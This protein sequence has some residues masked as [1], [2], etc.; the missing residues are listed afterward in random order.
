M[1]GFTLD[2]TFLNLESLN[3][4]PSTSFFLFDYF[5]GLLGTSTFGG[6]F[7]ASSFSI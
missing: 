3:S 4:W 7:L 2:S 6:D 1:R 5:A